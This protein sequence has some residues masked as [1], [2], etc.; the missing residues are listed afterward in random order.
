[1]LV[2]QALAAPTISRLTPPSELFASGR[3]APVVARFLPGQR[4]DLQAAFA[5]I[6]LCRAADKNRFAARFCKQRIHGRRV[7]LPC[8]I[9]DTFEIVDG[10]P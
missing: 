4:F 2:G 5:G 10:C 7:L 1:M 8:L 6:F 9:D 3:P